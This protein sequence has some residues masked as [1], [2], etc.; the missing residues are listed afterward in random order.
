[1]IKTVFRTEAEPIKV[2]ENL[3]YMQRSFI[4]LRIVIIKHTTFNV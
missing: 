2:N 4:Y 1:M 3:S